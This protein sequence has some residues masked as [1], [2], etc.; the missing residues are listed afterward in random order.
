MNGSA[1][2]DLMNI[3]GIDGSHLPGADC[4]RRGFSFDRFSH[5]KSLYEQAQKTASLFDHPEDFY[6][7]SWYK[8]TGFILANRYLRGLGV[9]DEDRRF[10]KEGEWEKIAEGWIP[11]VDEAIARGESAMPHGYPTLYRYVTLTEPYGAETEDY[12]AYWHP[13]NPEALEAFLGQFSVGSVIE[14]K[15]Y[16]ST[17][18][19]AD[20]IVAKEREK[21]FPGTN[22]VFEIATKRGI[23]AYTNGLRGSYNVQEVEREVLLPRG[24]KFRVHAIHRDV[25]FQ[26]DEIRSHGHF[27]RLLEDHERQAKVS[28]I[29]LIEVPAYEGEIANICYVDRKRK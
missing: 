27:P 25:T 4:V 12:A 21:N 5:Q 26:S 10:Y 20:Y 7:I 11:K 16:V 3:D 15:G 24:M 8:V 19:D 14:D 6:P 17:S 13:A 1:I 2:I 9:P 22:V 18:I 28:V 23:L 29:Q